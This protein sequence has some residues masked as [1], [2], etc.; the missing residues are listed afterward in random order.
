ML[1][2]VREDCRQIV[3]MAGIVSVCGPCCGTLKIEAMPEVK[4]DD[5]STG[6]VL[7]EMIKPVLS[8]IAGRELAMDN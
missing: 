4:W 5:L 8:E 3:D 2:F 1:K 7:S 6:M